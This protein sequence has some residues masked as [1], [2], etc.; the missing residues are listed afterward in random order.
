MNIRI[1]TVSISCYIL[2]VTCVT[3]SGVNYGSAT[4]TVTIPV[5]VIRVAFEVLISDDNILEGN[6]SFTLIINP[7]SLPNGVTVGDP[8]QAT[9][10]IVDNNGNIVM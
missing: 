2:N 7:S 10:V 5:G 9:V 3:G 6:R 1:F 4:Y 8:G